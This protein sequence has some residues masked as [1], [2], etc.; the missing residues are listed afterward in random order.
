MGLA[1]VGTW[2]TGP[3]WMAQTVQVAA[4]A[5]ANAIAPT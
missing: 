3:T 4:M 2:G 5:A 1:V